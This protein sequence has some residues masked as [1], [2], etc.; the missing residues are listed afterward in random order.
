VEREAG[1]AS[2]ARRRTPVWVHAASVGEVLCT[3]PLIRR[4][5]KACPSVPIVLTTM[6]RTGNET[7][8]RQVPEAERVCFLP[9]DHPLTLRRGFARIG[10]RLL[11]VAETELWPNLLTLCRKKSVPAVLFNGR[12]STRSFKR[13]RALRFFFRRCLGSVSL[14]LMQTE[15]DRLR[16]TDMV[17]AGAGGRGGKHQ[18]RPGAPAFTDEEAAGA[19]RSL[20]LE[21]AGPC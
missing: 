17:P 12:I 18:V 21:K 14:F 7:A 20:G 6:T 13:Y 11:L 5:R 1:R 9:F 2:G 4:I 3:L 15:E 19:G 16:I 10:P 8:R